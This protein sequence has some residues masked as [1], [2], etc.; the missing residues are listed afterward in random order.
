MKVGTSLSRCVRD[1]VDGTVNREDVMV[2]VARTDFDPD[3]D[4]QWSSI[5]AGYGGTGLHGHTSNP[6]WF[7]Y[8]DQEE[9]FRETCVWLK[10]SGKLHQPRQFGAFVS[11]QPEHWYDLI[12]TA[13]THE[14]NPAIKKSYENYK[15]LAG[16]M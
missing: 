8:A 10:V 6:E 16:L 14:D 9:K 13:E 3:D 7:G 2:V 15:M 4:K 12:L 5:W 11:P 1:I